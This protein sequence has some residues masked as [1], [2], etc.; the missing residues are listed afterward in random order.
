MLLIC[1]PCRLT[2]LEFLQYIGHP[3]KSGLPKLALEDLIKVQSKLSLGLAIH[4]K[5]FVS[6]SNLPYSDCSLH[7]L[8]MARANTY[9]HYRYHKCTIITQLDTKKSTIHFY[10]FIP[11]QK[12][13][14]L[15]E[16]ENKIFI[17]GEQTDRHTN[18]DI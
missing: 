9:V 10:H 8:I 13:S 5:Y 3:Q 16:H 17:W 18:T 6:L 4:G 11:Q 1:F 14:V 15:Y 12:V 7:R 2:W